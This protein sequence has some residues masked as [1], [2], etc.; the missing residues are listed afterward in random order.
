MTTPRDDT[1]PKR[2]LTTNNPLLDYLRLK[3]FVAT[4]TFTEEEV[5]APDFI[6][7]YTDTCRVAA[8]ST[9]FLTTALGL[10]W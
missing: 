7:L 3:S 10:A 8:A 1:A 6:D 5:C 9:G 4:T 2:R